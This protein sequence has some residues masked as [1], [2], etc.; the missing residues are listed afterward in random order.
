MSNMAA[1]NPEKRLF[2]EVSPE[3]P[4]GLTLSSIAGLLD[5]KLQPIHDSIMSLTQDLK[6]TKS[7]ADS[8]L[9]TANQNKDSLLIAHV[10]I[11][12][13]EKENRK[14][15]GDLDGLKETL[16]RQEAF[17]RRDNL[18]FIG[19]PETADENCDLTI[20]LFCQELG[21]SPDFVQ[22]M[23]IVRAHRLG[24]RK[25]NI[26]RPLLVRFH[27]YGDRLK[28]YQARKSLLENRR[29][30]YIVQ[31]FPQIIA[32]RRKKLMPLCRA[33][34]NYK[35]SHD[36]CLAVALVLDKLYIGGKTYSVDNMNSAPDFLRPQKCHI[37]ETETAVYFWS[38]EAPY[39]NHFPCEF[40]DSEGVSF[41]CA[42]QYIMAEKAN[43]FGDIYAS[44]KIM[45]TGD[46][47]EQ[48]R[49][50]GRVQ[51]YRESAWAEK[52]QEVMH[53]ALTL[54]FEQNPPLKSMLLATGDKELIEA[55]PTDCYWGIG[56]PLD[57]PNIKDKSKWRGQNMMGKSLM[58]VREELRKSEQ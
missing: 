22:N 14:L 37:V 13:L 49:L 35:D 26:D 15:S 48:K 20:R 33:A 16:L 27:F 17:S 41:N 54:K 18:K 21:L 39:S 31:D 43:I 44:Q 46:P 2:C 8:A 38:N 50:G 24:V 7:V 45:H 30:V 9:S 55:S 58:T 29:G 11:R 57:N 32:E 52:C 53:L 56:L 40:E 34:Y 6:A 25:P 3:S 36:S 23:K 10:K 1:G 51:G 42:E 4:Q 5:E 12:D 19:L 47:K 28:V